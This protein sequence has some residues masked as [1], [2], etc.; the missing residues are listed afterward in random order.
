MPELLKLKKSNCKNCYKCIRNCPVKS[1]KFSG[2][3]AHIVPEECI[4]CGEC[5]V[6]CPQDAKQIKD[7]TEIVK[8][9]LQ[10][11]DPVVASIAPSFAAYYDGVGIKALG[12]ALI[13]LGF[14]AGEETAIG[15][16]MVKREYEKLADKAE[17][18]NIITTSCPAINTLVQK[19]YPNLCGYLAPVMTPMAAHCTDIKRRMPNAKTVFIGPCLAKKA[20]AEIDSIDACLTFDELTAMLDK[21]NITLAQQADNDECSRAR[22]FPTE[23]GIL[24]TMTKRNPDY[25]YMTVSGTE[26][27]MDVLKDLQAGN[28]HHCFVEMS[29][30]AGSCI[31]GPIMRKYHDSP[32]RHYQ[33]IRRYAGEKDFEVVQPTSQYI[34]AGYDS[35]P[36]LEPLPSEEQIK[37]IFKEMGKHSK[38]DELNC[39]T[40]GYN[41]CRDKAIA[42]FRGKAEI[43]MCL[44]YLIDK[45]EHFSNAI[46]DNS[47][48]GIMVVNEALE[49]QQIN[50][51]MMKMM[52]IKSRSD[53]MGEP[54]MRIMD[55]ACFVKTMQTGR[56]INAQRDYY[57]E[58]DEFLEITILPDKNSGHLISFFRDVTDEEKQK[59]AKEELSRQ[60]AETADKV[61]DKQMR[62]V[63][64]IASLLGETAAETKI[65]L[66]QLK[67]SV[68]DGK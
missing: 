41:T 7:E 33:A 46:L 38:E 59:K 5:Y 1:I 65:V 45:S 21:A 57:A 55:P 34:N 52:H 27:C 24:D 13:A 36:L 40:C 15:A 50:T 12:D 25:T 2:N 31:S 11:S 18:D 63:Q 66:T 54:V 67:E 6:V 39:G 62:I 53:V 37:E 42:V 49:V 29:S 51:A 35:A 48:N 14:E 19:Y 8:V 58:F 60:T 23:G 22:L 16:T 3:Q 30:C 9:L 4:L 32:L 68:S 47:P 28:I 61:V 43:T 56:A 64:E 10:G 17:M 26:N 44:P 20:E